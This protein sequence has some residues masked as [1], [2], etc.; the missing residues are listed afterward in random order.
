MSAQQETEHSQTGLLRRNTVIA[1]LL[2]LGTLLACLTV[3][4]IFAISNSLEVPK[5]ERP[6]DVVFLPQNWT[7]V[8][9]HRYYHEA[10]GSELLP[11]AWFLAL[12][13]PRFTIRGAP[14][15]REDSY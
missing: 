7:E 12:E 5:I 4:L 13:Q 9:R 14:P 11:Y 2:L 6:R 8:Q 15:F 1:S 10:Q 3:V